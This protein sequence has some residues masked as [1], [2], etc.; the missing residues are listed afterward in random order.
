MTTDARFLI[1]RDALISSQK[2]Q[3]DALRRAQAQQWLALAKEYDDPGLIAH[4]E[5]K[6][7][8]LGGMEL[9]NVD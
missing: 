4:W 8:A 1:A 9:S 2:R 3:W 5:G 7:R 6:L